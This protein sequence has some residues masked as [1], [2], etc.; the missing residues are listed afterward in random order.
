MGARE[1]PWTEFGAT[2]GVNRKKKKK[3]NLKSKNDPE[4]GSQKNTKK[5]GEF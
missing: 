1:V 4:G 2:K 5:G 3:K